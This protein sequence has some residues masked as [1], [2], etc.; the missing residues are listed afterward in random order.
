[1][2]IYPPIKEK[3]GVSSLSKTDIGIPKLCVASPLSN[4]DK[5]SIIS[6]SI[7]PEPI[8]HMRARDL[9]LFTAAKPDAADDMYITASEAGVIIA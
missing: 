1:M 8:A 2:A 7:E 6:K 9:E 3:M 4:N 5:R